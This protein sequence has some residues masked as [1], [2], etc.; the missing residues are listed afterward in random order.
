M[1][2]QQIMF[3][4]GIDTDVGKTIATG[5]YA[6]QLMAQ[7][8]S[9]IT[10]KLVQTGCSGVA[11]DIQC[12]RKLQNLPLQQCDLDG[13]TCRYVFDYPCSPHLAARLAQTEI[14]LAQITADT[15]ILAQQ[16]DVVLIEG[17]GGLAVP[18]N[19]ELTTLD[20][21]QQQGYPLILV[22]SGKLGSINHTLLSLAVCQQRGIA[23]QAL[24]YNH[25]P[26]TDPIIEN[27]TQAYLQRYLSTHFPQ[28]EFVE[29]REVV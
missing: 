22:T 11:E 16:Y 9:V 14:D 5:F 12:H 3:I 7:G 24:I 8:R 18:L 6:N 15:Q 2:K 25:Y 27:E 4:S 29:L 23:L 13:T 20:Y 17:A 19:N 28:A 1:K 26:Q 21:L 10:Q